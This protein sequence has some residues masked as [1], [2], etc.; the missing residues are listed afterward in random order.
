MRVRVLDNFP[1]N[2]G[3]FTLVF[4]VPNM[5]RELGIVCIASVSEGLGMVVIACFELAS[6]KADVL[7]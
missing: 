1:V 5:L 7:F 3:V 4:R 6:N 2:G